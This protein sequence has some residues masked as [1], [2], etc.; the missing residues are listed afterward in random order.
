MYTESYQKEN[1]LLCS[2]TNEAV[3]WMLGQSGIV[4]GRVGSAIDYL[5]QHNSVMCDVLR[6]LTIVHRPQDPATE[7][8]ETSS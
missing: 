4:K 6:P 2:G 1:C 3:Q 5:D 7:A 8:E